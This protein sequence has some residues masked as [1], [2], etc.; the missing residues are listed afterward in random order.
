MRIFVLITFMAFCKVT[1]GQ[2]N[3]MKLTLPE[4]I[5][6]ASRQSIDA[7]KQQN[8]Y[9]ASYWAF[10]YYKAD[11]LPFLSVGANPFSYSNSNR[12]DYDYVNKQYIYSAQQN[13]TS[14]GSLKLNQNVGLTGGNVTVS[15]DLGMS[16]S[17]IGDKLTTFSANQI[18]FGYNQKVNG[19]NSMRWKA[20]IEPLK[21][22]MAKKRFYTIKRRYCSESCN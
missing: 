3:V 19:Y 11:K 14:S 10:K 4:V 9:L 6:L 12:Q 2:E 20:K 7:F 1:L 5:D 13:F 21:F 16:K 8:M 18:S 22:E 15:S 17:F